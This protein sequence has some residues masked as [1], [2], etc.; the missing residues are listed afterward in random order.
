MIMNNKCLF[1][2]SLLW[3]ANNSWLQAQS[4]TIERA[5]VEIR[6]TYKPEIRK[7]DKFYS[8]PLP[9]TASVAPPVINYS[10]VIMP[11]PAK[12]SP[13]LSPLKALALPQ[14]KIQKLYGNYIKLGFGNFNAPFLEGS[15][16]LLRSKTAAA[17]INLH[18]FSNNGKSDDRKWSE[19]TADA[20]LSLFKEKYTWTSRLEY[21]RDTRRLYSYNNFLYPIDD[22]A[23]IR[24]YNSVIK[25][26]SELL[27][28]NDL[29]RK[30]DL[31]FGWNSSFYALSNQYKQKENQFSTDGFIRGTYKG[32]SLALKSSLD[33]MG[34]EGFYTYNRVFF[35][36]TPSVDVKFGDILTTIGAR[37]VMRYADNNVITESKF[38]FYP[39]IQAKYTL[40]QF[41]LNLYASLSG[42][43]QASTRQNIYRE[44]PFVGDKIYLGN[45]QSNRLSYG[46]NARLGNKWTATLSGNYYYNTTLP[47][48]YYTYQSPY[49]SDSLS[50]FSLVYLQMNYQMYRAGAS[51]QD[52]NWSFRTNVCL[53]KYNFNEDSIGLMRPMAEADIH[54]EYRPDPKISLRTDIYLI[55]K[56]KVGYAD[57]QFSRFLPLTTARGYADFSLTADYRY[58]AHTAAF[59]TFRNISNSNYA[60]WVGYP[61]NG[62]NILGG[63]KLTF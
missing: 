50:R 10:Q 21:E 15:L 42:D 38:Y 48:F 37:A 34:F 26:S 17:G 61:V 12:V 52:G 23:L 58:N 24:I 43:M 57:E 63:V 7:G 30:H 20:Y 60:R 36:V 47:V 19:N 40:K 13:P 49:T 18:H 51:Y 1:I 11:S 6:R 39:D 35:K 16:M 54:L 3:L 2:L 56:R 14:S 59:L 62:I 32:N 46:A 5:T 27:S 44:N 28:R 31:Q 9:E 41:P 29:K 45:L 22:D 25:V 4:D 8:T 53:Y 55:S 33:V